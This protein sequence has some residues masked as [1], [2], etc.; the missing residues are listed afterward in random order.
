MAT[1]PSVLMMPLS[2]VYRAVTEA[3][4]AAYRSGWFRSFKLAAPVVSVGNITTGGTGKTPMVEWVCRTISTQTSN[5]DL[6][7]SICVL[8]RGYG[9]AD[10][11]AQVLVSNGKQI[12]ANE[13][14]AGDEPLLL[15]RNL[16]GIA[17]VVSNPDRVAAGEWA[18]RELGAKVFVLD[19]GFQHLRLARDLDLVTVDA[20]NPFGGGELL[21]KGRLREARHNLARAD[22][23]VI[24]RSDQT[25]DLV[26]VKESIRRLVGDRPIF[27]SRMETNG[28]RDLNG[29]AVGKSEIVKQRVGIF[30]GVGN[31]DSFSTQVRMTGVD[32]AFSRAFPDHHNFSADDLH[33]LV[34]QA[35]ETG[36]T[37]LLTT[38]KDATKLSDSQLSLPCYV[39][40]IR[41]AIDDEARLATMIDNAIKGAAA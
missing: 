30:C 5:A 8:T 3:R 38:A 22:C 26:S 6:L 21:P 24:T 39:L 11:K 35:R 12:L 2:T 34:L 33:H 27:I 40:E 23:V 9:K 10:P 32:I 14:E 28:F 17:S 36:A 16:L 15:A 41:I 25:S 19:D 13:R 20:T 31:P 18:L 37:C 29:A 4:L 1:S 7:K